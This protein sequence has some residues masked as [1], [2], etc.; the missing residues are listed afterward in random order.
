[1]AESIWESKW[2]KCHAETKV[3][4][5]FTSVLCYGQSVERCWNIAPWPRK[6]ELTSGAYGGFVQAYG[7]LPLAPLAWG[8]FGEM[9]QDTIHKTGLR[10]FSSELE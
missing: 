5:R 9:L 8:L 6:N 2:T 7:G 1:M 10:S 3:E 4:E